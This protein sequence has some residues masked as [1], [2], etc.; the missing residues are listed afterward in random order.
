MSGRSR[1]PAVASALVAVMRARPGYRDPESTSS[2]S[3]TPVYRSLAPTLT[4]DSP[5]PLLLVVAFSG[6][7]DERRSGGRF[8]QSFATS[9]RYQRDEDG[10]VACRATAQTGASELYDV[11]DTEAAAF[12]VLADVEDA[13]R[14]DP[15][16]GLTPDPRLVISL[17]DVT[18]IRTYSSGGVVTDLDFTVIY[19]ARI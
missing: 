8:R 11:D 13:L 2:T 18:D 12:A 14:V 16:A 19:S 10:E 17:G 3:L 15:T 4:A 5:V 9:G 7:P 6:T 1:W